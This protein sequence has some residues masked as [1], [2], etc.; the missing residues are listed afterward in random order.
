M[1]KRSRPF[2]V[3]PV[4][5][6]HIAVVE[7]KAA[8]LCQLQYFVEEEKLLSETFCRRHQYRLA[9]AASGVAPVVCAKGQI[10]CQ[11]V[12]EGD[13]DRLNPI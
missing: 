3:V 6:V 1:A 8:G 5:P 4:T 11:S 10:D 7:G 9:A 2:A 12:A 13:V